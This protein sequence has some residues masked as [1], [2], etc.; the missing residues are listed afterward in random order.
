MK[1]K[2][3]P[4]TANISETT[5]TTTTT[6]TN[7]NGSPATNKLHPVRPRP[8]NLSNQRVR[9]T[10]HGYSTPR[11]KQKLLSASAKALNICMFCPDPGLSFNCIQ[12]LTIDQR[13]KNSYIVGPKLSCNMVNFLCDFEL[14]QKLK[15]AIKF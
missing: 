13:R 2:G 14:T 1:H 9:T 3:V 7:G 12:E 6:T 8:H 5:T 11:C 15:N 4:I 10:W